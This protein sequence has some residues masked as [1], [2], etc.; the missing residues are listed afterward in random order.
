ML[1]DEDD[2]REYKFIWLKFDDMKGKEWKVTENSDNNF[3]LTKDLL[4]CFYDENG[5][6][7]QWLPYWFKVRQLWA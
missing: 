2:P 1:N 3:L 6:L 7:A 4:K 5:K